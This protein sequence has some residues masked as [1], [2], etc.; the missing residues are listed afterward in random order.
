MSMEIPEIPLDDLFN[1]INIDQCVTRLDDSQ[2]CILPGY[3]LTL[4]PIH[5]FVRKVLQTTRPGFIG[6]KSRHGRD[7]IDRLPLAR[8]YHAINNFLE[9]IPR[10]SRPYGYIGLFQHCCRLLHIDTDPLMRSPGSIQLQGMTGAEQFNR[11]LKRIR[12]EAYSTRHKEATEKLQRYSQE[13][14]SGF[15][16]YFDELLSLGRYSK[17]LI[18]RV[19]LYYYKVVSS[20]L[21]WQQALEDFT[22]L[23]AH[24]R[25]SSIFKGCVGYIRK[26]EYTPDKGPHFH[27]ILFFDGQ[28]RRSDYFIAKQICEHWETTI[29]GGKGYG[30]NCNHN[31]NQYYHWGMGM[32]TRNDHLKRANFLYALTYLCKKE[33]MLPLDVPKGT[34]VITRG[35]LPPS[36][37]PKTAHRSKLMQ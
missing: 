3:G 37:A 2:L 35:E 6:K 7:T 17:L 20:E 36:S 26:L 21:S 25:S 32:V 19:D 13:T 28:I 33:Q 15:R 31:P 23:L 22:R 5:E 4:W 10:D 24:R 11:L 30:H 8:Y 27:L 9:R 14:F 34:R 1:A 29:T 16:E 18:V 12:V